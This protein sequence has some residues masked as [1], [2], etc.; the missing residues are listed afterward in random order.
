M[1][2]NIIGEACG[3]IDWAKLNR[4]ILPMFTRIE[5]F[6]I[7]AERGVDH[8]AVGLDIPRKNMCEESWEEL[9]ALKACLEYRVWYPSV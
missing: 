5:T 1:S 8:D 7:P 4:R 9:D 6:P 3:F 2:F